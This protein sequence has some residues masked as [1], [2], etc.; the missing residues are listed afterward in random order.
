MSDLAPKHVEVESADGLSRRIAYLSDI[1]HAGDHPGLVWIPGF[2]SVMTSTKATYLAGWCQSRGR[3]FTRFDYTGFGQ[4]EGDFLTATISHWL[5][6]A[7]TIIERC[8]SGQQILLGSSMGGWIALL[9]LQ[10]FQQQQ[11]EIADRIAGLILIAPAWDMTER[12]MWR[13]LPDAART[14]LKT[15]GVWMRPSEY[16]DGPYPI[17]RNLIEDGRRHLLA[18]PDAKP[19]KS[20]CPIHIIHGQRDPDVPWQGTIELMDHLASDT[21][22]LTLIKDAEHRLSRPQDLDVLTQAVEVMTDRAQQ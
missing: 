15:T 17:T 1:G 5:D 14:E 8:T 2:R 4:S 13:S 9:A 21:I 16:D 18:A 19:L 10:R 20:G 22:T 6:D 12:L 11:P 3:T 7:L